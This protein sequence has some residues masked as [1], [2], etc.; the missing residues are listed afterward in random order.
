METSQVLANEQ[1]PQTTDWR[2]GRRFRV[3]EL[4]R[5]G[6]KQREI[7]EALGLSQGR[8]S[9]IVQAAQGQGFAGLRKQPASGAPAKLKAAQRQELLE[10]LKQGAPTFGFSGDLWTGKRIAQLIKEQF[11]V[12]YHKRHIPKLLRACGWSPQQPIVRVSQRDEAEIE[13][14]VAQRWPELKKKPPPK[15]E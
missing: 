14:W 2:E 7:A 8:I 15:T 11:G 3:L 13:A 5:Q 6:W 9:Q 4:H 10:L 12:H 1:A